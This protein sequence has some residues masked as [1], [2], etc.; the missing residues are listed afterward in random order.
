[1]LCRWSKQQYG[2]CSEP[3]CALPIECT[4]LPQVSLFPPAAIKRADMVGGN[5]FATRTHGRSQ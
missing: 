4:G 5:D 3:C 1:M 2:L